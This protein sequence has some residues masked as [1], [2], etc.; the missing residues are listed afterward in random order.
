M[1]PHELSYELREG[2]GKYLKQRRG[3]I[4]AGLLAAAA[5]GAVALYQTGIIRRLPQ[6][7]LRGFNT[8]KVHGSAQA[9][10][11][12]HTPDA[13]L[14][15]GSYALTAA[16]A[17]HGGEDRV[18]Q[19]PWVPLALGCKTAL[20]SAVAAKLTYDQA[21]KLRAFSVWSLFISACTYAMFLFALPEA[22]AA[23]RE[24][25]GIR[26]RSAMNAVARDLWQEHAAPIS[27]AEEALE[28][29]TKMLRGL[30]SEAAS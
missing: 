1:S 8:N 5:M 23:L 25:I 14:G 29:P 6:P 3:V 30:L 22:M 16:L 28:H 9:Y 19:N 26:A 7:P 12:L 10:A 11:L 2:A 13:L 15:M 17:A 24:L 18:R 27:I 4:G 21:R 20:D